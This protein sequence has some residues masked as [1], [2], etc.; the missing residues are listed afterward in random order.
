MCFSPLPATQ[1]AGEPCEPEM[2]MR[3]LFQSS[4]DETGLSE[5]YDR[6][7]LSPEE[8]HRLALGVLNGLYPRA[9]ITLP[10]LS[11]QGRQPQAPCTAAWSCCKVAG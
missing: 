11:A 1:N 10:S 5:G 8:G 3:E 2:E 4:E 6:V 7:G 9:A